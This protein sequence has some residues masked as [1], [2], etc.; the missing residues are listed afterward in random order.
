[1]QALREF[2]QPGG[3]V[4]L[5][6][7][8][9]K[10]RTTTSSVK[11]KAKNIHPGLMHDRKHGICDF[12]DSYRKD[13]FSHMHTVDFSICIPTKWWEKKQ[14]VARAERV[15]HTYKETGGRNEP[16]STTRHPTRLQHVV[17]CSRCW[18]FVVLQAS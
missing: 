13:T 14:T 6:E 8:I 12:M 9:T 4:T 17:V 15:R 16:G 18:I 2:C 1:M 5:T 11:V 10:F 3:Q 7:P